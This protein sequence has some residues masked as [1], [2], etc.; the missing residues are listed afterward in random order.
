MTA[1]TGAGEP[2]L[3]GSLALQTIAAAVIGGVSLR[4]GEGGVVSVLLG[5]VLITVMSNGMD[6]ARVDGYLQQVSFGLIIIGS[7]ALDRYGAP[8]TRD[9]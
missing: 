9:A 2:N 3:G 7:L 4:G 8:R 1:R 5:A 6:L